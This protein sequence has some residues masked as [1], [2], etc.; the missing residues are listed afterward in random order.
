MALSAAGQTLAMFVIAVLVF[1]VPLR[2]AQVLAVQY[3]CKTMLPEGRQL[4][5]VQT[6]IP[7]PIAVNIGQ[8]YVEGVKYTP[9]QIVR[10]MCTCLL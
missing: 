5:E 3:D 7:C 8:N 2:T 9:G 6:M 1:V 10:G 4:N